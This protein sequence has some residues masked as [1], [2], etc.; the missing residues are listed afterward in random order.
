[1]FTGRRLVEKSLFYASKKV[2]HFL[3]VFL[4]FKDFKNFKYFNEK[5]K[6]INYKKY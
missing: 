5:I 6:I 4:K 1:V 3:I 2:S